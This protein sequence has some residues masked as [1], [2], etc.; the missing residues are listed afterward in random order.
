MHSFPTLPREIWDT[1]TEVIPNED[2]M[3][4]AFMKSEIFYRALR[5]RYGNVKINKWTDPSTC[6]TL[7]H[8]R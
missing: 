2:L 1:V 5:L 3:R 6:R 4:I 7:E 8:I